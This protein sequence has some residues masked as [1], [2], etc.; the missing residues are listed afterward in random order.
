M[1]DYQPSQEATAYGTKLAVGAGVGFFGAI[2]LDQWVMITGI[3]CSVVIT[4]H[5]LWR[6]FNE[7]RD[8][9][10]RKAAHRGVEPEPWV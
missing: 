5:T 3:L 2:T 8:R 4:L 7:W 9:R 6:W 1:S 10:A